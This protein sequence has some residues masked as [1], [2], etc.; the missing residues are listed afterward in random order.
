MGDLTNS[1]VQRTVQNGIGNLRSSLARLSGSVDNVQRNSQHIEDVLRAVQGL[2][3]SLNNLA[4]RL[5]SSQVVQDEQ[6]LANI[7]Q[8]LQEVD[9]KLERIDSFCDSIYE[10][11]QHKQAADGFIKQ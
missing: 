4:N 8:K 6:R 11:M 7:D 3:G 9:A 2:Q 1:Q 10:Y 5:E